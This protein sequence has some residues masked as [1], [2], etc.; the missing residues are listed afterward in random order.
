MY[1]EINNIKKLRKIKGGDI[2]KKN[3]VIGLIIIFTMCFFWINPI[4]TYATDNTITYNISANRGPRISFNIS[5]SKNVIIN[6]NDNNGIKSIKIEKYSNS[7][8]SDISKK[9]SISNYKKT[10]SI[11]SNVISNSIFI[12]VIAIDNSSNNNYLKEIIKITKLSKPNSKGQ[13][14]SINRSP[15]VSLVSVP[16]RN[17]KSIDS[18]IFKTKDGNKIK[19]YSIQDINN[20]NNIY[21]Y[22]LSDK[23]E[24]YYIKIA[25]NKLKCKNDRY[26]IILNVTDTTNKPHIEK[27]EIAITSSNSKDS[28]KYLAHR[29]ASSLAPENTIEAFELAGKAKAFG[30]ETDIQCTSDG[31]LIC[32]HDPTVDRTTNGTGKISNMSLNQI[33]KLKIDT[34]SNINKYNNL[35]V[36]TFN[37]YLKICK[38]YDCYAIVELKKTLTQS[39]IKNVVKT[40]KSENMKNKC[41]IIS[42]DETVLNT[43]RKTDSSIKMGYLVKTASQSSINK[44]ISYKNCIICP[45]KISE[46]LIEYAKAKKVQIDVWTV[47][48]YQKKAILNNMGVDFITTNIVDM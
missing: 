15:R 41:I 44:A 35:S 45:G 8:W 27:M 43:V 31:K 14:Y 9:V 4:V 17:K 48:D 19:S 3:K 22:D 11:P 6:V 5:N 34:G 38:K 32:M 40:I 10:V 47:N 1:N 26:Y 28:I 46:E 29:G 16:C 24:I 23:K 18:F 20:N 37:E 13:Y 33:K 21:K 42:F 2:M 36:P 39:S 7:K 25:L 12:R 30:I